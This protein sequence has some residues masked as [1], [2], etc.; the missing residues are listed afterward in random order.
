MQ[1]GLP[2]SNGLVMKSK[3]PRRMLSTASSMVANAVRKTTDKAESVSCAAAQNIQ[4]FAVAHFLVRYD[5]IETKLGQ[6][7][8][9]VADAGCLALPHGP[10]A[11]DWKSG[12]AAC[13]ARHPRSISCPSFV[14]PVRSSWE[15]AWEFQS[16]SIPVSGSLILSTRSPP[17]ARTMLRAMARPSPFP[18]CLVVNNGSKMRST[19]SLWDRT[20]LDR[21]HRCV[22]R[23]LHSFQ[24]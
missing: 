8:P 5:C 7:T 12:S 23:R 15:N 18:L 9:R 22:S 6:G 2:A 3:E 13:A 16:K 10:H 21:S 14:L 1:A 19:V 4:P 11:S 24:L 17:C 20:R